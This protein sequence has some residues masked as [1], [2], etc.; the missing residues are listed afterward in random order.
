MKWKVTAQGVGPRRPEGDQVGRTAEAHGKKS[1]A[2]K[3]GQVRAAA[4]VAPRRSGRIAGGSGVERLATCVLPSFRGAP[5]RE[6]GVNAR[7]VGEAGESSQRRADWWW[8]SVR[9]TGGRSSGLAWRL[10][11][12]GVGRRRGPISAGNGGNGAYRIAP[13]GGAP[14]VVRG[15]WSGKRTSTFHWGPWRWRGI[16]NTAGRA[17]TVASTRRGYAAG[18]GGAVR[19][20]AGSWGGG[21]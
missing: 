18:I 14:S 12:L 4:G 13:V 17:L 10:K 11:S 8:L 3:A 9:V 15:A 19:F 7:C 2:G 16:L 5:G 21:T 1:G 20:G 6:A